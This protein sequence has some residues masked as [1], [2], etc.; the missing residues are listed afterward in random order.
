MHW[1][2][3]LASDI[4]A[5]AWASEGR[6]SALTGVRR[7]HVRVLVPEASPTFSSRPNPENTYGPCRAEVARAGR[8]M[9]S[10]EA[11]LL[12]HS[13]SQTSTRSKSK[14]CDSAAKKLLSGQ[15]SITL[16]KGQQWHQGKHANATP[17]AC[18]T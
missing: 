11:S 5:A 15:A 18:S 1:I 13:A 12:L 17:T 3:P 2:L 16:V 7:M 14:T 10:L 4:G 6:W 9:H 8:R